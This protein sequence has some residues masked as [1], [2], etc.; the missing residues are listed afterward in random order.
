MHCG[1]QKIKI[2]KKN[3]KQK[4]TTGLGLTDT[5]PQL[6]SSEPASIYVHRN[7]V[8]TVIS[9]DLLAVASIHRRYCQ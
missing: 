3:K 4:Q 2:K 7:Y 1:M 8:F 6:I 9:F 5:M